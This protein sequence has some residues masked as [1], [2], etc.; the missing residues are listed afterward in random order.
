M[1]SINKS[2]NSYR[3]SPRLGRVRR[4]FLLDITIKF[5]P[6]CIVV[7]SGERY[8]RR[9]LSAS[10]RKRAVPY[11]GV[12]SDMRKRDKSPQDVRDEDFPGLAIIKTLRDRCRSDLI[13]VRV[14]SP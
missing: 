1:V 8:T 6:L 14:S 5:L 13:L 4:E 2:R 9:Y 10:N 3:S 11:L 12:T 7:V